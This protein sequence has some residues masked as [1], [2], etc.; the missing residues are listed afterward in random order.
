MWQGASKQIY[1]LFRDNYHVVVG[2]ENVVC[3]ST[4]SFTTLV[5]DGCLKAPLTLARWES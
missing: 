4:V 1:L 3:R 2:G 5:M